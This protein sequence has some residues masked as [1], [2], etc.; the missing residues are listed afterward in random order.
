M[1]IVGLVRFHLK[2]PG[3]P[4]IFPNYRP[5]SN[6]AYVSKLTEKA[7]VAQLSSH[8]SS[9]APLP[10]LQS[11]YRR[12]HSTE[13]AL[14]K[15]Q[16]DIMSNMDQR[17]VTQLV[18]LD[19]SAAFDTIDHTIM[20]TTLRDRIGITATA[21]NWCDSYLANRHQVI[22][23]AG[24]TSGRFDLKYGVPQGSCLGPVLFTTYASPLFDVIN[25]HP[26]RASGY[27]DDHQLYQSFDPSRVHAEKEAISFMEQCIADV[28]SWMLANKLK[29][30]DSKTEYMIIGTK[31]ML[32]KVKST[33]VRVG[34]DD[35][36]ASTKV[37]NLGVIF[38]DHLNMSAHITKTCKAAQ[39]HLH[40]LRSIRKFL[41]KEAAETL[42]H[43]LIFSLLD[44]CNAL[45]YGLPSYQIARLQ[46]VQNA[47]ARFLCNTSKYDHISPILKSL[48]WL[49]VKYRILFKIAII[50]FKAL[51]DQAPSYLQEM[52]IRQSNSRYALRSDS[53]IFLKIPRSRH[54]TLG[55]RAFAVAAPTVWNALPSTVRDAA[56]LGQFKT[57][58]KTH[59]FKIAFNHL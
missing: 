15:V 29:I 13:T 11:A 57:R 56:T 27:A 25:Q 10:A 12:Y 19:L 20:S 34:V 3:L 48:H 32:S 46:R 58:L 24:A 51:T 33:S 16:S 36:Q 59:Y 44:Y 8:M 41:T 1:N 39:F 52:I 26:V 17:R 43:S 18:L 30:N 37:R 9:H 42:V 14:I 22:Q 7:V 4:P 5:I 53:S 47:A 38:D 21:L 35:I 40:N 45:L 55:D 54:K 6:L 31:A 49:P 2:K 28:R 23:V 50:T